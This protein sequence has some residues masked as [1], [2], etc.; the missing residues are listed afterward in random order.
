MADPTQIQSQ[1]N[2]LN[3]QVAAGN[4]AGYGVG[5][6]YAGQQIPQSVLTAAT[7][8]QNAPAT[9]TSG[10]GI[11]DDTFLGLL[12]NM[13]NVGQQNNQLVQQKNLI[14]KALF[15]QPLSQ[16]ELQSLPPDVAAIV[17]SGNQDQM[18]LQMQVIND[19]LQGRNQSVANSISYLTQG[20][21][22]NQTKTISAL[23]NLM[24]YSTNTGY[25]LGDLVQAMSPIL[26]K[27][28]TDQLSANLQKLGVA[29]YVKNALSENPALTG[30]GNM[31]LEQA[32]VSQESGGNYLAVS[33]AG[34]LG[35]Y[36]IMPSHLSDVTNPATGQPLDP[37]NPQDVQT[38]LNTPAL[39]D[40]EYQQIMNNLNTQYGGNTDKILAAYYGGDAAAQIVGTPAADKPQAGG[41][42]SINQYVANIEAKMWNTNDAT[43]PPSGSAGNDPII[44][45]RTPNYVWQSAIMLALDK[46]LTVQKFL[47]GLSGSSTDGKTLKNAIG[48]KSSALVTA[49]GVNQSELQQ[50]YA[51]ASATV[52]KQITD[53]NSVDASLK[54]ATTNGDQVINIFGQAGINLNDA[55]FANQ[56]LN[57]I[58]KQIG[59]SG[60]IRAYQAALQEVANDYSNVFSRGGMATVSSNARAQ[61]I[62][63]GNITIGD[64]Q[65]SLSTLQ[66]LGGGIISSRQN[67]LNNLDTTG[68]LSQ[69]YNYIYGSPTGNNSGGSNATPTPPPAGS[70]IN[71]QGK[72]YTVD[73][74]GNLTPQ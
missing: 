18:K 45:G 33:P 19:S 52:K 3:D 44:G 35:K 7:P 67:Q 51:G 68:T 14:S 41:M 31:S 56:T 43:P 1:I 39:Q 61:D 60:T 47:G 24:T 48:N 72:N 10:S 8:D 15:D 40:Q 6:Q 46:T 23:N 12:N 58:S 36:Q 55:T 37:N 73:A 64:L 11:P 27:S 54:S 13:N 49:S 25:Q 71:Y 28:V 22:A 30:S 74:Q 32:Q 9:P 62:L 26:G 53:L 66:T 70:V 69:F 50:A 57:D 63:N 17:Q 38:F 21:E 16:Q 20:Y 4:A 29:P 2:T 59:D 65:Q 5:G 34:A 42:P